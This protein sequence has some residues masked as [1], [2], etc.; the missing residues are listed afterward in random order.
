MNFH[1]AFNYYLQ[2]T[3]NTCRV[4]M[5]LD[6]RVSSRPNAGAQLK[7]FGALRPRG[8]AVRYEQSDFPIALN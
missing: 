4:V 2:A 8:S 7:R 1:I 6:C 5:F 3:C